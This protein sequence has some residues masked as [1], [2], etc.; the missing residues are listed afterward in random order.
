MV[1]V[2]DCETPNGGG[3]VEL[4]CEVCK[5]NVELAFELEEVELVV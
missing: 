2:S 1:I 5:S 3:R 4:W